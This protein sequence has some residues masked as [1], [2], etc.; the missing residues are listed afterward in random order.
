MFRWKCPECAM[1]RDILQEDSI[2]QRVWDPSVVYLQLS[3]DSH[4]GGILLVFCVLA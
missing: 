3:K 1:L 2:D 4:P